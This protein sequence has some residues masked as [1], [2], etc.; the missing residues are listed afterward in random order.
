VALST[1][2]EVYQ[3]MEIFE[4][5]DGG[6]RCSFFIDPKTREIMCTLNA[7]DLFYWAAADSVD[8][9]FEDIPLIN[10]TKEDCKFMK[11]EWPIWEDLFMCRKR[12]MRPQRAYCKYWGSSPEF[13][14]LLNA[15]GPEQGDRG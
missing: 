12:G 14:N 15:C 1:F 7:N 8:V 2:E 10:Q 6:F 13:V 11:A 9:D 5:G 3:L 4:D